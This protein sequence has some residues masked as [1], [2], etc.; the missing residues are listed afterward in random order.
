MPL[1][2]GGWGEVMGGDGWGGSIYDPLRLFVFCPGRIRKSR[3]SITPA[4]NVRKICKQRDKVVAR[5]GRTKT[6]DG[7]GKSKEKRVEQEEQKKV[8]RGIK[9]DAGREQK[10]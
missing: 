7:G 2:A 4:I 9:D 5:K 10:T 1:V 8:A 6:L 3:S